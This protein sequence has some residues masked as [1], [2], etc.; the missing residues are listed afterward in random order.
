[1]LNQ[2]IDLLMWIFLF[3]F[4]DEFVY[5]WN[6][7]IHDYNKLVPLIFYTSGKVVGTTLAP[8]LYAHRKKKRD[9]EKAT[10]LLAKAHPKP[11]KKRTK[12]QQKLEAAIQTATPEALLDPVEVEDIKSEI[13]ER[14][15]EKASDTI[16]KKVDEALNES[17]S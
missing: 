10:K 3:Y 13:R 2:T 14:A 5:N 6:H 12:K 7:G 9:Q 11:K 1:V 15:I 4:V 17:N 8:S 16:A